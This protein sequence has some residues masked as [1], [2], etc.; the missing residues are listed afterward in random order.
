MKWEYK[1]ETPPISLHPS[2]FKERK[3]AYLNKMGSEG[4][5]L[6]CIEKSMCYW[7]RPITDTT[8]IN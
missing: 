5:E 4:W 1:Y 7:K 6:V 2:N 8:T 3:L